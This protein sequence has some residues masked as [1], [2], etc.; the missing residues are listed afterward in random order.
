MRKMTVRRPTRRRAFTLVELL[1]VIAIIGI[2]VALL[3]PAVNAAREAA[4][5]IACK[6]SLRQLGLA[7][8]NF[9][10][11]QGALPPGGWIAAPPE[12]QA[13]NIEREYA[14]GSITNGCFDIHGLGPPAASWILLVLPYIEEQA[15][16]DR[17]DFSTSVYHQ[18]STNSVPPYSLGIGALTCPS[19]NSG[20][21]VNYNGRGLR[22][23]AQDPN[24]AEYG[25]AKGNYAAYISPVHMNHYRVR[26]ARSEDF[27]LANELV[28]KLCGLRTDCRKRF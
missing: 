2:L 14:A 15:L 22:T 8:L 10:S 24:L 26:P 4:R 20:N 27:G 3:L 25:M 18:L 21:T 16:H 7:V 17:F 11:S 12:G 1:V 6:N 23:F 5:R 19:D 9:E 13:C 28:K